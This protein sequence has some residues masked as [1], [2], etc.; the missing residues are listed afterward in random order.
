MTDPKIIHDEITATFG[1]TAAR[2]FE[3]SLLET[4]NRTLEDVGAHVELAGEYIQAVADDG[5]IVAVLPVYL[6]K[7]RTFGLMNSL[8]C[9]V[10]HEEPA[11]ENGV[12]RGESCEKAAD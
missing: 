9:R 10:C 11:H 2:H 6:A 7:T 1:A 5:E 8:R 4:F 12:C 3:D